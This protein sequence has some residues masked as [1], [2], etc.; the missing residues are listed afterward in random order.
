MMIVKR[1]FRTALAAA[2]L[3]PAP[4]AA[5]V[6]LTT[7]AGAADRPAYVEGQVLVRF[8]N[9]RAARALGAQMGLQT[10]GAQTVR[11]AQLVALPPG[12]SVAAA[13]AAMRTSPDVLSVQPNYIYRAQFTPDDPSFGAQTYLNPTYLNMPDA[14]D[15][16][17]GD[18]DI[19]TAVLD[20][21]IDLDHP[22]LINNL[23]INLTP[24][25]IAFSGRHGTQTFI[26]F[27]GNGTC[28]DT[29]PQNGPEQCRDDDPDDDQTGAFHGTHVAGIIAATT[30]NGNAIAGMAFGTRVMAVKVL[31]SAGTGTTFSIAQGIDFAVQNGADIINLSL[32]GP[33]RTDALIADAITEAFKQDVVV[34]AAS[35]NRLNPSVPCA[36]NHPAD[37]DGVIAVGATEL[38]PSLDLASFSCTGPEVDLVAPGE[39]ILSTTGGGGTSSLDGTSFSAPM[40]SATVALMRSLRP[41]LSVQDI[42]EILRAT[43]FDLGP[44]GP[45]ESYGFGFLRVVDAL[46]FV[47]DGGVPITNVI[48][49]G[50]TYPYPNPFQLTRYS[51]VKINVP[52]DLAGSSI[53]IEIFTLDGTSVREISGTNKWDGRNKDGELVASGLYFYHLKT[54]KGDATGKITVVK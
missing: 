51:S 13:V 25:P 27:N 33:G 29:H 24:N 49:P 14:W 20:T 8:R 44:G 11:G 53:D 50:E 1:I 36:V 39:S 15:I 21:G 16:A 3:A 23:W 37:I 9:P 38:D 12:Q 34:V 28:I 2:L 43:A 19:V 18:A 52:T 47:R 35:G 40:V 4:L 10:D 17:T 32:G 54:E 5:E 6:S 46:Q 48:E 26:D 31:N 45:D 7:A 42:S 30:G 41:S 22:D